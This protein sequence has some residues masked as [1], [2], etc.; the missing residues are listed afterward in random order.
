MSLNLAFIVGAALV[1][2]GIGGLALTEGLHSSSAGRLDWVEKHAYEAFPETLS[3]KTGDLVHVQGTVS[4]AEGVSDPNTGIHFDALVVERDV[5][6]YQWVEDHEDKTYTDRDGQE[7][8]R[9]VYEYNRRWVSSPVRSWDFH[10]RSYW[11]TGDLPFRDATFKANTVNLG[12]VQLSPEL[13]RLTVSALGQQRLD[14][15]SPELS[16]LSTRWTSTGN[17]RIGDVRVTYSAVKPSMVSVI[18]QYGDGTLKPFSAGI[19]ADSVGNG[20]ADVVRGEKRLAE[21]LGNSRSTS[22]LL[23][24]VFRVLSAGFL[25]G[26]AVLSWANRPKA[27]GRKSATA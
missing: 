16:T 27:S 26:G 23:A 7:R 12:G 15:A 11:N 2:V 9:R 22:G 25:V 19:A 18:A 20:Y 14:N 17:P 8:K 1:A 5:E 10:D 24:W 21:M 3:D 13:V 6:I 4:V